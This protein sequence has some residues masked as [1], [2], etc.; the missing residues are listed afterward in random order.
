MTREEMQRQVE[1]DRA[2]V[3]RAQEESRRIDATLKQSRRVRRD[4]LPK[5]RRL[6]QVR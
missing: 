1:E 4:S 5:L 6:G 2:A 3:Q